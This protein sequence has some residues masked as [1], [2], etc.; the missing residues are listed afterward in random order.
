MTKGLEIHAILVQNIHKAYLGHHKHK[1][2]ER[3]L[4]ECASKVLYQTRFLSPTIKDWIGNFV[5]A[6]ANHQQLRCCGVNL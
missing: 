3:L 4:H 6:T 5:K 1:R 2:N